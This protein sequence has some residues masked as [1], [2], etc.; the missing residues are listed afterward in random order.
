MQ[1]QGHIYSQP[2]KAQKALVQKVHKAARGRREAW[3]KQTRGGKKRKKA[4][5]GK[6][7]EEVR[8]MISHSVPPA[9]PGERVVDADLGARGGGHRSVV[10]EGIPLKLKWGPIPLCDATY[11]VCVSC[12]DNGTTVAAVCRWSWSHLMAWFARRKTKQNKLQWGWHEGDFPAC[13][14]AEVVH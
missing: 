14:A 9:P 1:I 7:V 11:R 10:F 13:T 5:W 4:Q 6:R 2:A 12:I 3:E 8:N